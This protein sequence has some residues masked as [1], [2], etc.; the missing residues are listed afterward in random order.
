ML[1]IAVALLLCSGSQ[2]AAGARAVPL[3]SLGLTGAPGAVEVVRPSDAGADTAA[4]VDGSS[5]LAHD[6][7]LTAAEADRVAA[8]RAWLAAGTVPGATAAQRRLATRALLDLRLLTSPQGASRAAGRGAWAY[9]WP[10]D[11]A[12]VAVAFAVTGHQAQARTVLRWVAAQQRPDGTWPARSHPDGS[13][14]VADGRPDQLDACGWFP[15]AVWAVAQLLRLADRPSDATSLEESLAGNVRAAAA[16]ATA[17]LG[18]DGTPAPSSD[19]W[20]LGTRG[21]TLGTAAALLVGLRAAAEVARDAADPAA[22]VA[23]RAGVVRLARAVQRRWVEHGATRSPNG[24]GGAD[25]AVVW[26]A[27]PFAPASPLVDLRVS[28][29]QRLLSVSNGGLR[30][31]TA[32]YDGVT[33]WTPATASFALAAATRGDTIGANGLLDWLAHHVTSLGALPEKVDARGRPASVA[34]LGWT[35]ALVLLTL[36]APARPLPVPAP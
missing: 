21:S 36:A 33:A 23:A 6:G 34:P 26:L 5:V 7:P 25:A 16:A 14:P 24:R 22:R 29:V 17:R 1:P 18:R 27:P 8:S 9:V 32:F 10:R 28:A 11:A 30:S 15:W 13:G 20:E 19:W 3:T 2:A 35:D 31:G 4:Y 12:F